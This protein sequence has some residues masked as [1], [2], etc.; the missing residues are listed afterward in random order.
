M[1]LNNITRPAIPYDSEKLP[2]YNRYNN[3]G[4]KPPTAAMIDGDLNSVIDNINIVINGVNGLEV[5][6][7]P[8]SDDVANAHKIL[9]T[10]GAA[11]EWRLLTDENIEPGGISAI[12]ILENTITG[13]DHGKICASA[14]TNFNIADNAVITQKINGLAVTTEKINN[15][16]VTT[17]KINNLAV[18]DAKVANN[19]I[20]I[21]K[22][23]STG[24]KSVIIGNDVDYTYTELALNAGLV[25]SV[26]VGEGAVT[27]N[28]IAYLAGITPITTAGITD[29]NITTGK[30]ANAAV[31]VD[32]IQDG[33]IS[34]NKLNPALSSLII[35]ASGSVNGNNSSFY[36]TYGCNN[37][38]RV[39]AGL[40]NVF[41][42]QNLPNANYV[43][44]A[45]A[46]N[47][48]ATTVS[49]SARTLNYFSL[50]I[51]R[52]YGADWIY[53]DS[54]FSFVIYSL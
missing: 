33:T 19:S 15:A 10:T 29:L 3:L 49:C 18:S 28:S 4:N 42:T 14:I 38:V 44:V 7:I 5:G 2:N 37:I 27:A 11:L 47:A 8:G 50:L 35:R 13:G 39:G 53:A 22:L 43:V 32:K 12:S 34:I 20:N 45:T 51:L 23:R 52:L 24:H 30:I 17:E 36:S 46:I 54:D 16:A 48:N 21:T 1:P 6:A 31:T 41:F 26:R 40:Y 25:P 9:S